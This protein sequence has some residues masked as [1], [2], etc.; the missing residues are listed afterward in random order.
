MNKP[1]S[2]RCRLR[3]RVL[4]KLSISES[5][6]RFKVDNHEVVL[7]P[8]L[9]DISISESEWLVM[10][11]RGFYSEQ[12]ARAFGCKL[13]ISLELSSVQCRLGVDAGTDLPTSGLGAEFRQHIE[14][15]SGLLVRD[16]IHGVDV[17]IDDPNVRIFN[18]SGTGSVSKL[19]EPF[20][21]DIA[22]IY[23]I[24]ESTSR[25]VRDIAL[26]LN[27]A[28]MRPEPVAQIVFAVSAVEM[29]GQDEDW[30]KEQKLLLAELAQSAKNSTIGMKE[31]REEVADS[32]TKSL[33]RLTLR[34][35]VLKLLARLELTYLK[36]E[37]DSL[38]TERSTLIH[39][40]APKSGEN[41]SELANRTMNLCGQI[42][43]KAISKEIELAGE[44]AE[45]FYPLA[46]RE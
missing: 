44:R 6:Y 37:W 43:L 3:F 45:K 1:D 4:K 38:Y 24:A 36:K 29:L 20:L 41:Y 19:P 32:I 13:K 7:A 31:E 27:Y 35:G 2:F 8:S 16:N 22:V 11:A 10:N 12:D 21:S 5:E 46:G 17:F 28:L 15:K 25:Q 39:G 33:H 42:L 34:Q 23:P 26:L 14:K 9:P 30:S 40:L 18:L